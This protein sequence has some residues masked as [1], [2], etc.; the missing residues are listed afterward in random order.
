MVKRS[1]HRTQHITHQYLTKAF[2]LVEILVVIVIVGIVCSFAAM[3][4]TLIADSYQLGQ[5]QTQEQRRLDTILKQMTH[6][7]SSALP[8]SI[9]IKANQ[10]D[11]LFHQTITAGIAD[12]IEENILFDNDNAS[13]E[14]LKDNMRLHIFNPRNLSFQDFEISRIDQNQSNLQAQGLHDGLAHHYWITDKTIRYYLNDGTLFQEI[15]SYG[16]NSHASG[17]HIMCRQVTHFFIR[18]IGSNQLSITLEI[19]NPVQN[20][21]LRATKS[22]LLN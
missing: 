21:R 18:Q 20:K 1:I 22:A 10:S 5:A 8:A 6:E 9:V 12:R 13:F 11:V 14:H 16:E 15:N 4:I 3:M 2:T 19:E 7:F 17:S